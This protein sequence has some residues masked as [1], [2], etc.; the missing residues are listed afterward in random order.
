[1]G[2]MVFFAAGGLGMH[3]YMLMSYARFLS[4]NNK[5]LLRRSSNQ[6]PN[7]EIEE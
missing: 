2:E 1:M 7:Q 3:I 5:Q 4:F 6:I